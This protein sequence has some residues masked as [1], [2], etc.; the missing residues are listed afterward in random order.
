MVKNFII[1]ASVTANFS[2]LYYFYEN[3]NPGTPPT[4]ASSTIATLDVPP[5]SLSGDELRLIQ[6]DHPEDDSARLTATAGFPVDWEGGDYA[7]LA[8]LLRSQLYPEDIVRQIVLATITRDQLLSSQNNDQSPY[9][10]E[11]RTDESANELLFAEQANKRLTLINIFGPEIVDD[12]LFEAL[13]KPLNDNLPFL[14]SDKQIAIYELRQRASVTARERSRGGFI[15]EMRE[16]RFR[17]AE[18][19]E[20][21]LRSILSV[22]EF[23]EYELR[24]SRL[25]DRMKETMVNFDYSEQEFRDI[26]AIRSEHEG[27]EFTK[28]RDRQSYRQQRNA[29]NEE[30]KNYLGTER[31]KEFERSQ[32]PT[33]RSLLAIGERYGNSTSEITEVYEISKATETEVSEIRSDDSLSQ[34]QRRDMI[35]EARNRSMEEITAI[36]GE[37]TAESIQS[38]S[39]RFRR[40]RGRR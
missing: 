36:A 40:F 33:Y 19:L 24:E 26:F 11:A 4:P 34:A 3:L 38:N 15:T 14:D 32:D 21:S 7:T 13:F 10:L 31:F 37:Q 22:D 39:N 28:L 16:D 17:D 2:F 25:S 23:I 27:S 5:S 6:S 30:I 8:E 1:I 12:P 29:S 18:K 9:W 20:A 35:E